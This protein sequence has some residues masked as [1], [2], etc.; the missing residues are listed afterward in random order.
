MRGDGICIVM[1]HLGNNL[2]SGLY[3]PTACNSNSYHI[4]R[5]DICLTTKTFF[6][7]NIGLKVLL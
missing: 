6:S 2:C 3:M 7:V 1:L 4:L 5:Y